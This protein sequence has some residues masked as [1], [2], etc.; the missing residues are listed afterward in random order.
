MHISLIKIEKAKE[1][2]KGLGSVQKVADILNCDDLALCRKFR[3]VG[4]EV[5]KSRYAGFNE[6]YFEKIDSPDKAYFLG[7][8]YADGNNFEKVNK[9]SIN[10]VEEDSYI[11]ELFKK[12]INSTHPLSKTKPPKEHHKVQRVIQIYSKKMSQDLHNLGCVNAK[13]LILTF[14]SEEIVP[15]ELQSHFI[16]GYFDGD[17]SIG[18][19][20]N[21]YN[22]SFRLTGTQEFLLEVKG[23]LEKECSL[24]NVNLYKHD[25]IYNLTYG[26]NFQTA[27]IAEYLYKDCGN[28]FFTRKKERFE[29][30][31]VIVETPKEIKLCSK[32]GCNNKHASKGLCRTHYSYM[33]Y[34]KRKEK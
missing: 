33:M 29:E 26:G 32:E 31:K 10:L 6:S 9:V 15:K 30:I 3:E 28:L 22:P 12:Y 24:N 25:N 16:R 7:L 1:L 20:N 5:K 14:P 21:Y 17:G 18:S 27:R 11:I 19:P 23:I 13:S 8:F 34:Y 4:V 2:Y